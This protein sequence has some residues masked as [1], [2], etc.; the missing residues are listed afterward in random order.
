MIP[1]LSQW[2]LDKNGIYKVLK[3]Q[4]LKINESWLKQ[5]MSEKIVQCCILGRHAGLWPS[6]G[7]FPEAKTFFASYFFSAAQ[8]SRPGK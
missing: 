4:I 7:R 3:M 6:G 1:T 5:S 8:A 2:P